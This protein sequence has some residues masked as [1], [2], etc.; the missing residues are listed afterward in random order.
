MCPSSAPLLALLFPYGAKEPDSAGQRRVWAFG[1]GRGGPILEVPGLD[2]PGPKRTFGAK[3][4]GRYRLQGSDSG[5][6]RSEMPSGLELRSSLGGDNRGQAVGNRTRRPKLAPLSGSS[7]GHP[8]PLRCHRGFMALRWPTGGPPRSRRLEAGLAENPE[9]PC[10]FAPLRLTPSGVFEYFGMCPR[11]AE[12]KPTNPVRT[13]Q[14]AAVSV[15]IV[16]AGCLGHFF[17]DVTTY[18]AQRPTL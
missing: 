7:P 3:R 13:P 16:A 10:F 17:S 8:G 2:D 4:G 15:V 1:R 9:N 14:V 12:R 18:P 6:H 5:L 11:S